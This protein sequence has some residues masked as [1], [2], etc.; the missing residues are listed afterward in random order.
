MTK[1]TMNMYHRLT[2]GEIRKMLDE[3]QAWL[4]GKETGKRCADLV[5][6]LCG[7]DLHG[8]NL[9]EADL[10]GINLSDAN[11]RGADLLKADLTRADLQNANISNASMSLT[12]LEG[13]DLRGAD[14][15]GADLEW[16][17]LRFVNMFETDLR[18][19]CLNNANLDRADARFAIG[20]LPLPVADPRHYGA[21]AVLHDEGW[22]VCAGCHEFTVAEAREHWGEE[23]CGDKAIGDSYLAACDWLERAANS[24]LNAEPAQEG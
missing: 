22:R 24:M 19:A 5:G 16:A 14:L 6:N 11:L 18:G 21:H 4:L 3:H 8:A 13:A 1:T 2:T 17:D 20:Y 9:R 12:A 23:Y 7:A 15:R 10:A